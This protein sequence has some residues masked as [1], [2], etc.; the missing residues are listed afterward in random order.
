MIYTVL[1]VGIQSYI[2][3]YIFLNKFQLTSSI[4]GQLMLQLCRLVL[5]IRQVLTQFIA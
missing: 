4:D 3:L 2:A 5:Y 1:H